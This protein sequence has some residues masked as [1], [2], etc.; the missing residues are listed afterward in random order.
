MSAD[1]SA[2]EE[3]RI[4]RQEEAP[5]PR[6]WRW[7]AVATALVALALG[8]WG[9]LARP[10]PLPVRVAAVKEAGGAAAGAVLNATGYVTARRQ[11]TVS[12]KVTGKVLEVLIEEG[13][14]VAQGQVLARLDDKTQRAALALADAQ[15][16]QARGAL[17]ENE[18]RL[19]QATINR[20]RQHRLLAGGATT[21]NDVDAADAEADSFAARLALGRQQVEVAARELAARRQDVDDTVIRAPFA[22]VITTKDAQPGEMISPISAGG[23]FTRTGIGTLVDMTSL[24]IDVDVNES[25]INRVKS[26]QQAEAALD[27]YPDWQIPASVIAVVPSADRQKATVK[28][29]LAFDHLDPR[30]LPDMGVKVAFLA[31]SRETAGAR[32]GE[33]AAANAAAGAGTS[34]ASAAA[35]AGQGGATPADQAGARAQA[36]MPRAALRQDRAGQPVVFVLRGDRVERR[37]VR[38]GEAPG[39]EVAVLA[40]L[41]PGEQV[42][43]DPPPELTD[44]RKVIVR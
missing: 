16:A 36:R 13:M 18:V 15:L 11:A 41:A 9:W 17:A 23:G 7:I 12:S 39:D 34:G 20:Q 21:Q 2:L 37:A 35:G 30:I 31:G 8:L 38:V 44:G 28:V 5:P 25:Y 29:R 32:A 19:R 43:V 26:A 1:R 22:G 6:R 3:L 24:E 42:V 14:P 33:A 10:A 40:G 27:A 4:E